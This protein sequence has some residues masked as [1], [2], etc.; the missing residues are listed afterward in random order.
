MSYKHPSPESS[1]QFILDEY[2]LFVAYQSC[3]SRSRIF[4]FLG[5]VDNNF[6]LYET[7][8]NDL[9]TG[10]VK[11]VSPLMFLYLIEPHLPLIP[12][13]GVSP[14]PSWLSKALNYDK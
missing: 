3:S 6:V 4:T 8:L 13:N 14:L 10:S 12:A 7:T 2:N 9:D 11:S 1:A 5:R